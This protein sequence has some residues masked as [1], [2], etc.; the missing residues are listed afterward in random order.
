MKGLIISTVRL[1]RALKSAACTQMPQNQTVAEP[2]RLAVRPI[3]GLMAHFSAHVLRGSSPPAISPLLTS[4]FSSQIYSASR[5]GASFRGS[6][7]PASTV[8]RHNQVWVSPLLT[9]CFFSRIYSTSRGG[10]SFRGFS[11]PSSITSGHPTIFGSCLFR[12]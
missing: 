5:G 6:C 7:R 1:F 9:S 8:S 3:L 10:A 12:P 4:C 2:I 11:Q